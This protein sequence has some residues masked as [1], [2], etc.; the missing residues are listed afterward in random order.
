M[1]TTKTQYC[2]ESKR[3]Q[4]IFRGS[5]RNADRSAALTAASTPIHGTYLYDLYVLR[6]VYLINRSLIN[7]NK[8][9]RFFM[10]TQ[11][12]IDLHI[13]QLHNIRVQK[14]NRSIIQRAYL[15]LTHSLYDTQQF[16]N[17]N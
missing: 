5:W 8:Y 13:P 4:E 12:Y 3:K 1:K 6:A 14:K 17:V 10:I 11:S 7:S 15:I 2:F 9:N 16:L